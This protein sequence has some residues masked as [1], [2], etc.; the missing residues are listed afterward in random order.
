MPDPQTLQEAFK[1]VRDILTEQ[2]GDSAGIQDLIRQMQQGILEKAP[3]LVRQT[4]GA[5]K[6]GGP[7][8]HT[9]QIK[10]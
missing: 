1:E 8:P 5:P 4:G 6:D 10:Q 7:A 3:D 2:Q 9:K